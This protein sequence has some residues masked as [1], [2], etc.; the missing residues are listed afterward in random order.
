MS[1]VY[2]GTGLYASGGATSACAHPLGI[3]ERAVIAL[4]LER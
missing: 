1:L 2:V 3:A 4:G